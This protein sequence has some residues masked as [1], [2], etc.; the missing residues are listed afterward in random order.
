MRNEEMRLKRK[1]HGKKWN[2]KK[3][4]RKLQNIYNNL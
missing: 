1:V 2:M 4:E 3:E